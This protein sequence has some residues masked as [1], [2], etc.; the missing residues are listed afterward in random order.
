MNF[1]INPICIQGI[2]CHSIKFYSNNHLAIENAI[3][4]FE[5]KAFK[6]GTPIYSFGSQKIKLC[7]YLRKHGVEISESYLMDNIVKA[8]P[9]TWDVAIKNIFQRHHPNR[10]SIL[11]EW[12]EVVECGVHPLWI[13]FKQEKMIPRSTVRD[14]ILRKEHAYNILKKRGFRP[15]IAHLVSAIVNT[16]PSTWPIKAIN[17]KIKEKFPDMVDLAIMLENIERFVATIFLIGIV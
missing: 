15:H 8:L 12:L 7:Q 5:N 9:L 2:M 13:E 4:E 17:R 10:A 1:F 6:E 11:V 3:E 14:H 16:L